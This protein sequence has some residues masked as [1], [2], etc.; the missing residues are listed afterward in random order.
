MD[1]VEYHNTQY[2]D[3]SELEI[4][5]PN[6]K[7]FPIKRNKERQILFRGHESLRYNKVFFP[8]ERELEFFSVR[9]MSFSNLLGSKYFFRIEEVRESQFL[10]IFEKT[11]MSMKARIRLYYH[12]D[13]EYHSFFTAL[14]EDEKTVK[15]SY[16]RNGIVVFHQIL[17]KIEDDEF[18]VIYH[19]TTI[20]DEEI[21]STNS[22][23]DVTNKCVFILRN[24]KV[25][26]CCSETGV[27]ISVFYFEDREI[28][29]FDLYLN[30]N[31]TIEIE[32]ILYK[33]P[34]LSEKDKKS[35]GAY[36][37]YVFT[38]ERYLSNFDRL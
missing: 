7:C 13:F 31:F 5:Y 8:G 37:E 29:S 24:G 26:Q 32:G 20:F 35:F 18:E 16:H 38:L 11:T 33:I 6:F 22:L 19:H 3:I 9:G 30:E 21:N 36:K 34:E 2:V 15:I 4:E 27:V 12:Y 23:V 14:F 10:K 17:R 1:L 28:A 25:Y